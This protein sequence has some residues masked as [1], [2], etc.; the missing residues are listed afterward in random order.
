MTLI[1]NLALHSSFLWKLEEPSAANT[2]S[3]LHRNRLSET[4]CSKAQIDKATNS[5]AE[6]RHSNQKKKKQYN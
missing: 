3:K 5:F 2:N 4:D 6:N 1:S